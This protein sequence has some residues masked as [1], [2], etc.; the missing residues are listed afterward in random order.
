MNTLRLTGVCQVKGEGNVMV[1]IHMHTCT[2]GMS[3]TPGSFCAL[4]SFHTL[5]YWLTSHVHG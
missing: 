4:G 3:S 2:P 1:L 5:H